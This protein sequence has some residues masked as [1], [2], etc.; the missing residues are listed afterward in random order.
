MFG[1]T[2]A[3]VL[4]CTVALVLFSDA[5]G[6][7]VTA[8]KNFTT[9]NF[10]WLFLL[11]GLAIFLFALW[12]AFGPYGHIKFGDPDEKPEY[13]NAH[14]IGMMFTAGVGGGLL[15]WG[16][17]EP[18][19]YLKAPPF[20]IE[21][22][23][24]T[25]IEWAHMYPLFHWGLVPWAIYAIPAVP[26]AYMLYVRK[27]PTL[28]ISSACDAALPV[29]GRATIKT[30]ID[31]F[32]IMGIIGGTA[33]AL[34]L[35]APLVSAFVAELFGIEDTFA[36]KLGVLV[37]WTVLFGGSCYRGLKKGIQVLADINMVLAVL[38]ILFVFVVGPTLFI[39]NM[40]INSLGLMINNFWQ[41]S[42]WTD[43]VSRS[44]F[45]EEWTVFYWSWW[46]AFS[47]YIGLFFG[48]ISRGRTV[49]SLVLGVIVFGTLG[50]WMFLA[51]VGGY[52]LHLHANELMPVAEI[53]ANEGIF[54]MS[55]KVL[56]SLP[57]GK[58]TLLA[59]TVL[60]VI[61]YATNIDSAA[62]VLSSI[63]TRNLP[64]SEEPDRSTRIIWAVLLALLTGGLIKLGGLAVVQAATIVSSLPLIPIMLLMCIS[65]VRWL[66]ASE[67]IPGRQPAV[68]PSD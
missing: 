29:T 39:L 2:L 31:I 14:W 54:V 56:V 5:A 50:T 51:V 37:L 41:M 42:L 18:L 13:S 30:V 21:P 9:G 57:L 55:A 59:F 67:K 27:T 40:S 60:A 48:R 15:V 19:F 65:L 44:G 45:P 10:G 8:A 4:L 64:N 6:V 63:C 35:G 36:V 22:Y 52:A 58:L 24:S 16:F 43:P 11:A 28:R 33:T 20:G 17:A 34:G 1:P 3:V 32:I 12:L 53:L 61:F 49:R 23:S 62:Y 25:S 26:I 66:A 46:L 38:L 68:S 7:A 47:A